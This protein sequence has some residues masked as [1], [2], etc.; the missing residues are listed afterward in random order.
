MTYTALWFTYWTCISV[1]DWL[2]EWVLSNDNLCESLSLAVAM[3]YDVRLCNLIASSSGEAI[4]NKTD[5]LS[6]RQ[7]FLIFTRS[8]RYI[9]TQLFNLHNMPRWNPYNLQENA[10]SAIQNPKIYKDEH[11]YYTEFWNLQG[12]A[13]LLTGDEL[14]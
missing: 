4:I 10:H 1:C 14:T 13:Q 9:A 5:M 7:K 2:G 3:R 8:V 12:H 6:Y 11:S